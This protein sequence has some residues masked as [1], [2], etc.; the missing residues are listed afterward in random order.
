MNVNRYEYRN[1]NYR[2]GVNADGPS[3][4]TLS[5]IDIADLDGAPMAML[6]TY[7]V[8]PTATLGT[9]QVSSDIARERP[10][11]QLKRVSAGGS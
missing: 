2:L 1:S 6:M 11:A 7:A 9:K 3:D 8:H 10:R 5:V 4:K